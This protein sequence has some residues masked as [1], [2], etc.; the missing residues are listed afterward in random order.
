MK[1]L[2]T[3]GSG[4]IGGHLTDQLVNDGHDV[5]V[6]DNESAE[7]SD[8]FYWRDDTENHKV[9]ILDYE[10]L[11]PL[12]KNVDWVFHMAAES[13]VMTATENPRR[14]VEV[15]SSGT[16][17]VLQAARVNNVKRLMYSSTSAAYGLTEIVPQ[18][19]KVELDCLN[20]YSTSKVCGEEICKMYTKLFGLDTIIFR[21]FNVYGERAPTRGQYA[22]VVG[23]F[24]KQVE[25]GKPITIVGDGE[26]RRDMIHVS[27]IVQANLA[28]AKTEKTEAFGQIFNIGTGVNYSVNQM[29]ELIGGETTN[30]DPRPG[31][32]RVTL[33]DSSKAK[34]LLDWQSKVNFKEWVINNK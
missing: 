22:P 19:E 16:C 9:D 32:A 2:V 13:R 24:L 33:S 31:E 28:A 20:P 34:E 29:A 27:D 12:F 26:Q 11:E 3:G 7:T 18:D 4:F 1:C 5:I 25:E 8:N 30:L 21:Y 23:R 14:A 6:I 15:N 17:N 10:N